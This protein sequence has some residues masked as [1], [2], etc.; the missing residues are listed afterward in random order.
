MAGSRQHRSIQLYPERDSTARRALFDLVVSPWPLILWVTFRKMVDRTDPLQIFLDILRGPNRD[1]YAW[2]DVDD[3]EL[4]QAL[5]KD[6]KLGLYPQ[7]WNQYMVEIDFKTWLQIRNMT[8]VAT[9]SRARWGPDNLRIRLAAL[10][11]A[12]SSTLDGSRNI[13]P[14]N[15]GLNLFPFSVM[16]NVVHKNYKDMAASGRL[17]SKEFWEGPN[18]I[19]W[20]STCS[21]DICHTIWH[22]SSHMSVLQRVQSM[23]LI[24]TRPLDVSAFFYDQMK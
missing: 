14:L 10:A 22:T 3:L 21:H 24:L 7:E 4:H 18:L 5:A 11:L 19:R 20:L 15:I 12:F 8:R 6:N 9:R 23:H 1:L 13:L 16:T 17:L 2:D